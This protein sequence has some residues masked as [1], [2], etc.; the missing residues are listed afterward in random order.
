MSD[1]NKNEKHKVPAK[2]CQIADP[3]M[4]QIYNC[5]IFL[6]E[7]LGFYFMLKPSRNKYFFSPFIISNCN[8]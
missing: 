8:V 5:Q 3:A 1:I 6:K 4:M 7:I 2:K